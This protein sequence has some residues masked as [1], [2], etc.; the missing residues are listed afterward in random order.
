[1]DEEKVGAESVDD[2]AFADDECPVYDDD[3][4]MVGGCVDDMS[5]RWGE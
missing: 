4:D 5:T 1:M 2:V 3:D